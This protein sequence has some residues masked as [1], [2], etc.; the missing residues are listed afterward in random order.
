MVIQS[1]SN[2]S[3]YYLN[4]PDNDSKNNITQ[5]Y[6]DLLKSDIPTTDRHR[7]I[8][9]DQNIVIIM[10]DSTSAIAMAHSVKEVGHTILLPESKIVGLQG[11]GT[12]AM[13]FLID[14]ESLLLTYSNPIPTTAAIKDCSSTTELR[15]LS[16][17]STRSG[18]KNNSSGAMLLSP[19]ILEHFLKAETQ[20]PMEL[21]QIV[22][23][24]QQAYEAS[25]QDDQDLVKQIESYSEAL[26]DFLW[27]VAHGDIS[28]V[29]TS[30]RPT[31]AD[32]MQHLS[33]RQQE[34]IATPSNTSLS[35]SG[36]TDSIFNQLSSSISAQTEESRKSNEIRVIEL[37][38]LKEKEEN[39]KDN[40]SKLHPTVKNMFLMAASQDSDRKATSLA[41]SGISYF[42]QSTD[43][44]ALQDLHFSFKARGCEELSISEA[45]NSSI[46]SGNLT[47]NDASTPSNFSVFSLIINQ[48]GCTSNNQALMLHLKQTNKTLMTNNDV[49][50]LMKNCIQLPEDFDE[51]QLMLKGLT[52]FS[53]IFFDSS[54]LTMCIKI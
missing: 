19:W 50:K 34:C 36:V 43:G 22:L 46:R 1:S 38:R 17:A 31:D 11:F 21:L 33:S 2:W 28:P 10:P 13:P 12:N 51:F 4:H 42:A 18:R 54:A 26:I 44:A 45:T 16:A 23:K 52:A 48:P 25:N 7:T 53:D 9:S 14:Q 5:Q 24:A 27:S 40:F 6:S 41:K 8:T 49:K 29:K 47:W 39:K 3:E 32:L 30:F 37:A 35:S 15:N 20:D